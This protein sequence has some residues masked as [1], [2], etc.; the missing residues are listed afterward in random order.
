[1]DPDQLLAELRE[2]AVAARGRPA[3]RTSARRTPIPSRYY[4]LRA[5]LRDLVALS[6][7]PAAWI[8][9]EPSPVATG[10][11]D[12]PG[13]N[14]CELDFA[15]VRLSDPGW[16]WSSR[17]HAGERLEGVS[18]VAGNATS[19]RALQFPGKEITPGRRQR[20]ARA[21]PR[22]CRPDRLQRRGGVVAAACDTP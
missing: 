19:P 11:A 9:R 21:M 5:V 10:L 16:C 8:G 6:A 14:C 22:P 1:M 12:A 17:R 7:I 3:C 4:R 20:L 18:G 13:R 15:F 2:A